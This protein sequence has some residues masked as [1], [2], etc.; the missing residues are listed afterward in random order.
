MSSAQVTFDD[1]QRAIQGENMTVSGGNIENGGKKS[2][3]RVIGEFNSPDELNDVIVKSFGGAVRLRDIADVTFNE[4]ERTTYARESGVNV[5]SVSIKKRSGKNMIHAI[6]KVKVKVVELQ[7]TAI[8]KDVLVEYTG[9][10]SSRVEHAVDELSNHIIFGIILV[11]LV[12]MFTMGLR[13]S[14]FVG[15]AIPL[16]ML[17]AFA[18]LDW[19]G[20]TLNTMVLF[21]LVMGLGMLVDDGIVVV[22]NVFANLQKGMSR[23]EASKIGIGEIAWPVISS[24]ATTLAAFFPLGL[25]PGTMGKFMIYFP[26]TLSVVLFA[27]LFVAMIINAS[28]TGGFMTLKD[29]NI[30]RSNVNKYTKILVI[31]GLVLSIPGWILDYSILKSFGHLSFILVGFVWLYHK[32]IFNAT[33]KFQL[34]TFPRFENWYGMFLA[35]L[36]DNKRYEIRNYFPIAVLYQF[37]KLKIQGKTFSW[38]KMNVSKATIALMSIVGLLFFS[39]ILMSLFPRKVLFFPDN[40]PNM[41]IVY[42]E[43]PQGTPIE[44][45][46]EATKKVEREVLEILKKYR[47]K[48]TTKGFLVQSVLSQVGEGAG[49]PRADAGN[50]SETPFKGK[51]TVLY[52]EFNKRK[53]INTQEIL[54]SMQKIVSPIPGAKIS[55]EKEENG[56]PRGYPISVDLTGEDYDEMLKEGQN[57]IDFI[58]SKKIPGIAQLGI[59]INKDK[60][61]LKMTIDR[62]LAGSLMTSTGQVGFQLRRAIYGQEIST[63]KEGDDDYKIVMRLQD[64]QRK[65]QSTVLNQPIIVWNY[66][67]YC[68]SIQFDFQDCC[69]LSYGSPKFFWCFLWIDIC[70]YEFRYFDDY[71]GNHITCWCSCQEWYRFDGLFRFAPR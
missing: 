38:P 14:L 2:N 18:F 46:N 12:L 37:I 36:L 63:Y 11:M 40:V 42:I 25:W 24:T 43:Y 53:G 13:N 34:D 31:A 55:I 29:D 65:Q 71:D 10:Q 48:D 35:N 61:E 66:D 27:S 5:I 21:G 28:M 8:P 70:Q 1:V 26:A 3:I 16:S 22:D 68:T 56:P 67:N 54:D 47:Q 23:I 45:T 49:N 50:T 4:K 20:V 30:S 57:I 64:S 33:Q 44:K 39:V 62:T 32:Y 15:S 59:N 41:N 6:E 17:M 7:K 19:Y 60:P 52:T 69:Y 58:N 9:D 51:V